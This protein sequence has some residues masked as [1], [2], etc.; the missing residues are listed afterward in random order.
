M[1]DPEVLSTAEIADRLGI[2]VWKVARWI[3]SRRLQGGQNMGRWWAT[4]ES[5]ERVAAELA[6]ERREI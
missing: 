2:E 3:Q 5:V 6:E 1:A 4:R